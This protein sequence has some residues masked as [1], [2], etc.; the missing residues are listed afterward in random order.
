MHGQKNIKLQQYISFY[1]YRDDMF[2]PTDHLYQTINKVHAVNII[3]FT[4][5]VYCNVVYCNVVYCCVVLKM[6]T[7]LLSFSSKRS[8][9]TVHDL[10]WR[11]KNTGNCAE[12]LKPFS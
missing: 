11:E 6:G 8:D 2:R 7:V 9:Y 1:L 10:L 12:C 5:Y 3:T 4:Q